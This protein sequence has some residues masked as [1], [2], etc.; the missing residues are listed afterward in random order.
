M[1]APAPLPNN[2]VSRIEDLRDQGRRLSDLLAVH[3]R[4]IMG[5]AGGGQDVMEALTQAQM[6]RSAVDGAV[7]SLEQALRE[8]GHAPSPEP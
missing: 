7:R 8:A 3:A 5:S 6:V 1:G 4:D 2:L